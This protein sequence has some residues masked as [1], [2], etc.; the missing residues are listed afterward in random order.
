[1]Y[2]LTETSSTIALLAPDDHREA[3]GSADPLIRARLD[4][5]G[6]PV[7]G[8]EVAILGKGGEPVATGT[9]GRLWV[10]G[11]QVSGEYR[12]TGNAL[13]KDGW[14]DTHDLAHQDVDGFL[15][16]EGRSDDT[17]IRGG[18]NIAPVEIEDVLIQH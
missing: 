7:P 9:T 4:S 18:E 15:F 6:R 8:I 17:I 2:G 10:R 12:G 11:R 1:A 13:S 3:F 5:V 14:F 16:I